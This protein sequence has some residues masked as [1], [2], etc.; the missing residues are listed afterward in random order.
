VIPWIP[1]VALE[2]MACPTVFMSRRRGTCWLS[3]KPLGL[4]LEKTLY[5]RQS[6]KGGKPDLLVAASFRGCYR[7]TEEISRWKLPTKNEPE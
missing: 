5:F 3:E 7:A 1:R 2:T 4:V 6:K